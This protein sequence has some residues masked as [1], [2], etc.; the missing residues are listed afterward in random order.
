[1]RKDTSN[2]FADNLVL[3]AEGME[4]SVTGRGVKQSAFL[5]GTIRSSDEKP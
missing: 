3:S 4:S 5:V 1:M 2:T